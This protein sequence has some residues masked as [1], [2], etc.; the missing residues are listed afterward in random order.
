[1]G[2][3]LRRCSSKKIG[4]AEVDD[5]MICLHIDKVYSLLDNFREEDKKEHQYVC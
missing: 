5:K 3:Y 4:M 2:S 1:M